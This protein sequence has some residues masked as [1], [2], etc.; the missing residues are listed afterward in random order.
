MESPQKSSCANHL[1]PACH[2]APQARESGVTISFHPFSGSTST[3][4]ACLP[5]RCADTQLPFYSLPGPRG[6]L[7]KARSQAAKN[8]LSAGLMTTPPFMPLAYFG[9][10][11]KLAEGQR[12]VAL[13]GIAMGRV[14]VKAP[15]R[16]K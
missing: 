3:R 14:F 1:P 2:L 8:R 7:R 10:S 6:K 11:P 13:K 5:V 9:A 15:P 12:P 4:A 16:C